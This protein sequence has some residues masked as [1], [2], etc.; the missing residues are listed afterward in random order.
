MQKKRL[1]NFKKALESNIYKMKQINEQT[2]WD[3]I[4]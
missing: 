3:N 2:Q 1:V 4:M